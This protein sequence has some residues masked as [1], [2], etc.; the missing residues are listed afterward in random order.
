[1]LFK[2][3]HYNTLCPINIISFINKSKEENFIN[4]AS[5]FLFYEC[6]DF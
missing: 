6:M 2:L 4:I 5:Q 1:M 3:N